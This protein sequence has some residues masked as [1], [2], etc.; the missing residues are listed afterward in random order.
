MLVSICMCVYK[1]ESLEK[2]LASIVSQKMPEG[3]ALE[4]VVVDNDVEESGRVR[5]EKFQQSQS[6]VDIRYFVNG[7]RNLSV[8]RNATMEHANGD[9]FLFIDDD[10]WASTDDWLAQLIATMNEYN[11]DLVFGKV[12]VH[13]PDGTPQWIVDGNLLGK[14]PFPHG[15]K[16]TKGATSNALMKA[17]WYRDRGFAFDPFFGK[18]GGEDTDLFNRIYKA[19]GKLIYDA[20]ALVE[21]IAETQRLNLDYI[22]KLNI[23]IG[24]THYHYLWCRQHGL[25]SVKTALFVIAQVAGYGLLALIS[26]PFNKGR[27]LRW[28]VRLVRNLEK[29][30]MI[31][32]GGKGSVELYGN[33]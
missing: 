33:N 27:A 32:T 10:E 18:S 11:A 24:Q 17:H 16:L 6:A 15:K 19:G 8:L 29:L 21:E 2:T 7:V 28:Y 13:Y 23:R 3:Y 25:A 9:L 1:R 12:L 31:I 5:C 20:H 30:K 26:Y 22:K 14:V 4:V